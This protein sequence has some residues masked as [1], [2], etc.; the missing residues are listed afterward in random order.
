MK[1]LPLAILIMAIIYIWL[2]PSDPLTIKI[3][4]KL[5]PMLLIL[6]YAYLQKPF[7]S[8]RNRW[9]IL[10]GLFFCMQGDW[11]ITWF[12]FGLSSFLVGHLFYVGGFLT[13]WR[14]SR[15]R[16]MMI[17]PIAVYAIYMGST[18]I[19]HLSKGETSLIVPVIFYITVISTMVWS[20]IMTANKWAI[21]GSVLFMISD[22]I[23]SWNK[24]ISH[25]SYS[26]V[27]IMTTYYI[28]QFFIAKSIQASTV[29]QT[30]SP[31]NSL[32]K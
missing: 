29:D 4:F 14:Y 12:I 9:L 28:A 25:I 7:A 8:S 20:A 15:V 23:L 16:L 1:R 22:S 3:L 31:A 32:N 5:V 26:D 18:I 13:K 11:L 24:F 2:I 27:L 19:H 17:L 10:T 6:F 30:L 21:I